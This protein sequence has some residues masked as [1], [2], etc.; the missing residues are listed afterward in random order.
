MI[1]E[2]ENS[3]KTLLRKHLIRTTILALTTATLT[4]LPAMAQDSTAAPQ[5][6]QSAPSQSGHGTPGQRQEHQLQSLT[7]KLNLTPDQVTQ[8]KAIEDDSQQ[9]MM[10][11]RSDSSVAD[12]DR[13]TKMMDIRKSS[14][15]KIRAVLT[16]EQKPKFD[17]LMAQRQQHMQEHRAEQGT[18]AAAPPQ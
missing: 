14:Q 6:D 4:A 15:D 9:Q 18:S 11:L 7:K 5:Q 16:D 13:R 12:Q 17:A 10:A 3:M 2:S 8:V 1:Y